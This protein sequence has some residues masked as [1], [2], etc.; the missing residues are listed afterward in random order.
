VLTINDKTA[1]LLSIL[2]LIAGL[3]LVIERRELALYSLDETILIILSVLLPII[4]TFASYITYDAQ[5][6]KGLGKLVYWSF[7][8]LIF[9]P[10]VYLFC[11]GK[12]IGFFGV[13]LIGLGFA[14]GGVLILS[15]KNN[16]PSLK[17]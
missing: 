8:P 1:R 12:N 4:G 17:K 9:F 14:F 5:V 6:V 10:I 13:G 3:A 15:E 11:G 2:S 7:V 16:R